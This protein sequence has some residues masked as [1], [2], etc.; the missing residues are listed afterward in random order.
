MKFW[1]TTLAALFAL[2]LITGC[3]PKEEA[4]PTDETAPME[5]AAPMEDAAPAAE[6]ASTEPGGYEPTDEERI[7][8]AEESSGS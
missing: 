4:A 2:T 5:E 3:G 7:P 8:P 6:P 1:S